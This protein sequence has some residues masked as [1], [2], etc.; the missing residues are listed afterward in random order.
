MNFSE[1]NRMKVLIVTTELIGTGP[2]HVV[3]NLLK[4]MIAENIDVCV[5]GLRE[6]KD[7]SFVDKIISIG[8]EVH[9]LKSSFP[10][11]ELHKIIRNLRPTL[12]NTHGIKPDLYVSFLGVF[13]KFKHF[14]TIHNVPYEDYIFRYGKVVGNLMVYCHSVIFNSKKVGKICVSSNIEK[15]LIRRGAKK[16]FTVYNGVDSKIYNSVNRV[17]NKVKQVVFC[18]QLVDLKDPQ[19]IIK[20]AKR[21]P[22]VEF[23]I[24]GDGPLRNDLVS[25][26]SNNVALC[27]NVDNVQSYFSRSDILLMPSKTEGMPMVLLEGLFCGLDAITTDITI[28]KE[29]ANIEGVNIYQYTKD[30]IDSLEIVLK[31]VLYNQ[32]D[33]TD[34]DILE[35]KLSSKAMCKK[36]LNIFHNDDS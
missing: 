32:V 14:S 7:S 33:K 5:V 3:F 12:I 6:S 1:P 11:L 13:N 4:E 29:I 22:D 17:S 31:N 34:L 36:Y 8:V 28:F 18:G 25:T 24:L 23:T 10:I 16:T 2:N 9:Q 35:T 19:A 26:A 15:H 27:G 20:V 30:D 21:F